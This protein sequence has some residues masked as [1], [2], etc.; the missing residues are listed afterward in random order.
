MIEATKLYTWISVWMTLT[1]IQSHSCVRIKKNFG[2][3]FLSNFWVDLDE[4]QYVATT[5]WFVEA[6]AE[7]CFAQANFKE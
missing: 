2:V 5:H 6:H 3:H 4:I 1:F 7:H